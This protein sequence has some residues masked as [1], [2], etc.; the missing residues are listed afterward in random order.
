MERDK[1]HLVVSETPRRRSNVVKLGPRGSRSGTRVG[2]K[3]PPTPRQPPL[4]GSIT[5]TGLT[6]SA[7]P[8]VASLLIYHLQHHKTCRLHIS[9]PIPP[10]WLYKLLC[11]ILSTLVPSTGSPHTYLL[12]QM[13]RYHRVILSMKD[14]Q[15]AGNVL[16]T[17]KQMT[18]SQELRQSEASR[19]DIFFPTLVPQRVPCCCQTKSVKN[20]ACNHLQGFSTAQC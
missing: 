4:Q 11:V 18:A 2:L 12:S 13:K 10:A 17:V 5:G 15:G 14:E 3:L 8:S 19:L 7:S 20:R 9:V 1:L 6:S 16:H